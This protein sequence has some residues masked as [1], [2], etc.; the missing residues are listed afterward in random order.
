MP[1]GR[2]LAAAI[3]ACDCVRVCEGGV[4]T[5]VKRVDW[6]ENIADFGLLT[7]LE[8]GEGEGEPF[9]AKGLLRCDILGAFTVE[10]GVCKVS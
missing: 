5:L 6:E 4:V 9:R 1:T 2:R 8:A 7:P 10:I 3:E